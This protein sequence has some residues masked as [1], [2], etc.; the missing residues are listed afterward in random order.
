MRFVL[1]FILIL[2]ISPFANA[3]TKLLAPHLEASL[4]QSHDWTVTHPAPD[5][6][7]LV[8][9]NQKQALLIKEYRSSL[10]VTVS[11]NYLRDLFPKQ[12]VA[13]RL[14]QL[15]FKN[16]N[17]KN[18]VALT[19]I[20]R[21]RRYGQFTFDLDLPD[22]VAS[23]NER[24]WPSQG[25]L[26]QVTMANYGEVIA[27]PQTDKINEVMA[28][29]MD[30]TLHKTSWLQFVLPD[31]YASEVVSAQTGQAAP[32]SGR[33][34]NSCDAF[35]IDSSIRGESAP[36]IKV[37]MSSITGCMSGAGDAFPKMVESAKKAFVSSLEDITQKTEA[38]L[39]RHP[40]TEPE[41]AGG[42]AG[43][44][45]YSAEIESYNNCLESAGTTAIIQKA[46]DI[47]GQ[48]ASGVSALAQWVWTTKDP[49]AVIGAMIGNKV[50]G[51]ECLNAATQAKMVCEFI[52]K[53]LI[54]TA[55]TVATSGMSATAVAALSGA[56]GA[57][58]LEE[59][60]RAA[61]AAL[62]LPP[63]TRRVAEAGK[64]VVKDE[65]V[66][67]PVTA[68]RPVALA[69][70]PAMAPAA[71][72]SEPSFAVI[73]KRLQ[74][75]DARRKAAADTAEVAQTKRIKDEIGADDPRVADA[76]ASNKR[77]AVSQVIYSP[78][79]RLAGRTASATEEK[80]KTSKLLNPRSAGAGNH[81]AEVVELEDGTKAVWKQHEEKFG[82]NYR[83]EILAF[84]LDQKFGFNQ[85]PITVER[86][87]NGK[88]GSLQL[89]HDSKK[90]LTPEASEVR[91][92]KLFDF[93]TDNRDRFYANTLTNREAKVVSIDN[94]SSFMA[95][96]NN[97]TSFLAKRADLDRFLPSDEGKQIISKLKSS[98]DDSQ[99]AAEMHDYLG[100]PDADRLLKRIKFIVD[101]S[102]KLGK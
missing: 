7:L 87:I 5:R 56:K 11:E 69:P 90:N 62:L 88:K 44:L 55:T 97:G 82:S 48:T 49:V 68:V 6:V 37:Q 86:S 52:S 8:N 63:K 95:Q 77:L 22:G 92:Q 9:K 24:I 28:S 15:K 73:N 71:V 47:V 10:S 46:G 14:K 78:L 64:Q 66:I 40:C 31:A 12:A 39:Q 84:E 43:W 91:K 42:I 51:F 101:Y 79:K 65:V 81:G 50:T 102:E 25:R 61:R 76:L 80:M 41:H 20:Y 19:G 21:E 98:I 67:A 60:L 29:V 23:F 26:W 58:V 18:P 94:G 2:I 74:A 70:V 36:S 57:V 96:G 75:Y 30:A 4:K 35:E 45:T 34:D 83:A 38:N 1:T 72:E 53:A 27:S 3:G 85:V 59:G 33:T 17:I 89:F 99:F 32:S 93:I 54:A 100:K 13:E 16:L